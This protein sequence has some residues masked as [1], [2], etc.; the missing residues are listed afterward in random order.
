MPTTP[1]RPTVR[2][3]AL[4]ENTLG[5]RT[6]TAMTA[7]GYALPV[8][9][10]TH[11][12]FAVDDSVEAVAALRA[13]FI[14]YERRRKRVPKIL[15][16]LLTRMAARR[17]LL[18]RALLRSD[19]A[20]LGGLSTYV[21]KL[22]ADNLVPPF[23]DRVDRQVA[24]SPAGFAI[25]LRL[26][27]TARLL[28][29]GLEQDRRAGAVRCGTDRR[30]PRASRDYFGPEA[31]RDGAG[32]RRETTF[33]RPQLDAPPG[34]TRLTSIELKP[35]PSSVFLTCSNAFSELTSIPDSVMSATRFDVPRR[36]GQ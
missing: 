8:I 28:A 20:F 27:Q 21:L 5:E 13:A 25:R 9:D 32:R 31:L 12:A 17:S 19:E 7:D 1:S 2:E 34:P 33:L 30:C 23:D 16:I 18:L 26:Q 24:A 29:E 22:G 10:V 4:G 36:M 6:I 14:K 35:V 3:K 11:P 15:W